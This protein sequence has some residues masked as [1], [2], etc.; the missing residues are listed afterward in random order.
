MSDTT[1]ELIPLLLPDDEE[2]YSWS[3]RYMTKEEAEKTITMNVDN[4]CRDSMSK[5]IIESNYQSVVDM[6]YEEELNGYL[7]DYEVAKEI[8]STIFVGLIIGVVVALVISWF[9]DRY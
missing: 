5:E 7:K 6:G 3:L 2:G 9:I 4:Y 8:V 1:E